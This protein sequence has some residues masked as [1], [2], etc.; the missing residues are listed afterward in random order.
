[1]DYKD[2]WLNEAGK[3]HPRLAKKQKSYSK[4]DPP[5]YKVKPVPIQLV[6]HSILANQTNEFQKGL[7]NITIT[8]FFYLLRPGK[9]TYNTKENHPFRLQDVSF[10]LNQ[11]TSNATTV[12]PSDL[13]TATKVHLE[14]RDQKNGVKGKSNYT[15][16]QS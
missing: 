8:G 16:R 12:T 3:L 11:Q 6:R 14:F 7:A 4:V 15:W 9:Y 1:M 5:P 2:P 10:Q 13:N